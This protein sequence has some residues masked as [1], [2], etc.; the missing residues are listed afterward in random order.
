M[1]CLGT[2]VL[3]CLEDGAGD[4]VVDALEVGEAD[5]DEEAHEVGVGF[6]KFGGGGL[7]AFAGVFGEPDGGGWPKGFT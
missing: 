4:V 5:V 1:L 6:V 3:G 7:D 2:V